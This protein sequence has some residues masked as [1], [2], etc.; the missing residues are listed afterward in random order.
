MASPPCGSNRPERKNPL[1]FESYA[2]LRDTFRAP[3]V[4]RRRRR[5]RR[6]HPNGGNFCSGGDVHEIIGPLVGMDMKQLLALHAHDRRSGEGDDR[7][8]QADHL[9]GRRCVRRCR[10]DHRHGIGPAPG[11]ARGD[12]GVP[13]HP[14]R[15]G[16]VRHGRLR[17][18]AAH[19][20][21]GTGRRAAVHRTLDE[22]GRGR[23]LGLLQRA[24]S[25]GRTGRARRWRWRG[26]WPTDP[27]SPT[28]SPRRS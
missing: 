20:R 14:R 9:G 8:R 28:A 26:G 3:A 5:R 23:A 12:D 1:T 25:G 16:R 7:L 22:R 2:E 6:S 4:R 10:G 13:V 17:H 11:D 15:P 27:P 19:H 24:A 18:A 21:A